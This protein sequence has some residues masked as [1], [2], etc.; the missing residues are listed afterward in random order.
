MQSIRDAKAIV[1]VMKE[2]GGFETDAELAEF[3]GVSKVT[4]ASWRKRNSVPIDKCIVFS[5][6]KM[7]SLDRLIFGDE[8]DL[9][10]GESI[11]NAWAIG[12]AIHFYEVAHGNFLYG[13]KWRTSL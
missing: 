1:A 4:I 10:L 9:N 3:L 11:V 7:I 13:D 2:R 8:T 6:K 12:V 5:Q